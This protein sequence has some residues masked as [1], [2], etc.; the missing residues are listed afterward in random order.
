MKNWYGCQ[1]WRDFEP[2]RTRCREYGCRKSLDAVEDE[3]DELVDADFV[4]GVHFLGVAVSKDQTAGHGAVAKQGR[5]AGEGGRLHFEVVNLQFA[6]ARH[7]AKG[8][9]LLVLLGILYANT[10]LSALWT[11]EASASDGDAA[12]H[13][14]SCHLLDEGRVGSCHV[15]CSLL[16]TPVHVLNESL[17]HVKVA[18][19]VAACIIVEQAI[20]ADA[21]DAGYECADGCFGLYAA[22]GADADYREG[23]MFGLFLTRL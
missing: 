21:L 15:W 9:D 22:A 5:E 1:G 14:L 17:F 13:F 7:V 8:L 10:N 16:W 12:K 6:L 4:V 19:F 2:W 18:Y 20:E 3:F 11:V 23:T